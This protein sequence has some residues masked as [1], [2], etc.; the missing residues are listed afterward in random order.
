MPEGYVVA[1]GTA[2]TGPRA[3]AWRVAAPVTVLGAG[4]LF[5]LS[6]TTARGT[7]LRASRSDLATLVSQQRA[8]VQGREQVAAQWR[9]QVAA[10]TRTA[11]AGDSTIA[12]E[13]AGSGP[14]AGLFTRCGHLSTLWIV[15]GYESHGCDLSGLAA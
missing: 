13:Q 4:L 8:D 10:A 1:V 2:S 6:A 14:S 3:L 5:A 11:A 15:V 7:D 12:R 9:R